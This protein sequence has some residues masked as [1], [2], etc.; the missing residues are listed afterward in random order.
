MPYCGALAPLA[1]AR[2]LVSFGFKGWLALPLSALGP[3]LD[4]VRVRSDA[5]Q[6]RLGARAAAA[7]ALVGCARFGYESLGS[8]VQDDAQQGAAPE[9]RLARGG[10]DSG[11][12]PRIDDCPTPCA[13]VVSASCADA[14]C[15]PSCAPGYGDC[16]GNPSNG[17]ESLL[18]RDPLHCG[19]CLSRC[20]LST[21]L[22][23]AGRCESS[24]CPAGRGECDGDPTLACEADL[25]SVQHCGFCA[26][27]CELPNAT[28]A[29]N[30]GRCEVQSCVP[31]F[32]DCDG[33]PDNGCEA[34]LG[35]VQHCSACNDVCTGNG[36]APVCN[37]GV[38]DT[39]CDLNGVFALKLTAA[40]SW[41]ENAAIYSGSGTFETWFRVAAAH[42]GNTLA[43]GVTECGRT[44]PAEQNQLVA[45]TMRTLFPNALFDGGFLPSSSA[46]VSLGS[47][48]P[49]ASLSWPLTVTQMGVSLANPA[50]DSWPSDAANL[51]AASLIDMDGDGKPGVTLTYAN[52]GGYIYPRT[53][54]SPFSTTRADL[55]YVGARL[56][57][58][59]GGTLTSCS[60]ASGTAQIP[61]YDR[62]IVGCNRASSTQDCNSS[63]RSILDTY[64]P[65]W[66]MGAASFALQAVAADANCAAVRAALP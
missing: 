11:P 43:V 66:T 38:C 8:P 40:G 23:Q 13:E 55:A 1:L 34:T 53:S 19:S 29:C 20:D 32:L 33:A 62:G 36:G 47:S 5:G 21:Q 31:G 51:P 28:P 25:G 52:G 45:E 22:C 63:E 56:G 9:Q 6:R 26:N 35:S 10:P 50:T 30:A 39:L 49:G 48:N 64:K 65:A 37:A 2:G 15:A 18:D 16:D 14:G 60:T 17:C 27:S 24:S 54:S 42:G 3:A 4:S 12:V 61:L 7:L 59:L 44:V 58:S 46:T 57:F 41:P